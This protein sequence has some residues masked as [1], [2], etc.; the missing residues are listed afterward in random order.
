ML[1]K[2]LNATAKIVAEIRALRTKKISNMRRT[3]RYRLFSASWLHE[4]CCLV[5]KDI[6][7][8]GNI[9]TV[10]NVVYTCSFHKTTDDLD[11]LYFLLTSIAV[12]ILRIYPTIS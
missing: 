8:A 2:H 12:K 11:T 6:E 7:Y 10:Q 9:V 1:G 3:Y 5:C 4:G